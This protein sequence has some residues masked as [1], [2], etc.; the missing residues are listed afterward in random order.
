MAPYVSGQLIP[1]LVH[2]CHR[3]LTYSRWTSHHIAK[4]RL[5]SIFFGFV[6]ILKSSFCRI[7]VGILKWVQYDFVSYSFLLYIIKRLSNSGNK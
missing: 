7:E 1:Y 4:T 6:F 5:K 3:C 2:V